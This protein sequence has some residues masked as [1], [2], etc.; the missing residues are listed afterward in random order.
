M[1]NVVIKCPHCQKPMQVPDNVAGKTVKCPSCTKPFQVPALAAAAANAP[2]V[3]RPQSN[4]E[5]N[6]AAAK[7]AAPAGAPKVAQAAPKPATPTKC[8]AC[9]SPLNE[10]AVSCMDCGFLLTAGDTKQE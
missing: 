5:I 9:S 7:Q 3:A 2:T 1:P 8:P 6:I 4:P 10:G